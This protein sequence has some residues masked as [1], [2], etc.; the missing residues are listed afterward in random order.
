MASLLVRW[1]HKWLPVG[2]GVWFGEDHYLLIRTAKNGFVVDG[3]FVPVEACHG[4]THFQR[5]MN[6]WRSRQ[7][8][9]K[10]TAKMESLSRHAEPGEFR[11]SFPDLL[12]FMTA[13]RYEGS[14][15]RR[16]SPTVT[17]WCQGGQW[18][19]SLRDRAEG[20]VLWLSAESL[21]E[22]LQLAEAFVMD[23]SAPWRHDDGNHPRDGKRVRK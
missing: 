15:E 10:D 19:L 14:D 7:M 8:K 12:E 9:R 13:A 3:A 23:D 16:E 22:V 6:Y 2:L 21:L 18:R 4:A 5:V 17:V 1:T 11:E 20:L